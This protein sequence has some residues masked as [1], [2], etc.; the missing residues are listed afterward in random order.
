MV[1]KGFAV[2]LI[3]G[4][5]NVYGAVVAGLILGLVDGLSAGYGFRNGPTPIPSR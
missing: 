5:G 2:A 3:G 1:V 4:L